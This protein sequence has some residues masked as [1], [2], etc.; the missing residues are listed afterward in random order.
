[1]EQSH[2]AHEKVG[3]P[4]PKVAFGEGPLATRST[5]SGAMSSWAARL[6]SDFLKMWR[7]KGLRQLE[8]VAL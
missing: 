3:F 4:P 6:F 8:S 1:M 7:E 5:P 2:R